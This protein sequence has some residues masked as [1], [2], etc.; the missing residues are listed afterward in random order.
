[1]QAGYAIMKQKN[2][3]TAVKGLNKYELSFL[4]MADG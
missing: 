1:M 4:W 3:L 2:V